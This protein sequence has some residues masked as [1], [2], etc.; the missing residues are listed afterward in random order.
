MISIAVD[1]R[2]RIR[3]FTPADCDDLVLYADNPGIARFL[4][5]AFPQPYTRRDA[6]AWVRI[7]SGARPETDLAIE[8]D[9]RCAGG[10]GIALRRD[11]ERFTGEIGFWVGE[12]FW[13]RGI[14]TR[15]VRAFVDWSFLAFDFARIEAFTFAGNPAS[16]RVLE[17]SGFVREGVRRRAAFKDGVFHD[18]VVFAR[19]REE[20]A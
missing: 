11:I 1:D 4:R 19:L 12:P 6:L 10:I 7:A 2:V 14:A 15:A 13:N 8:V 20:A 17:K 18:L 16:A 5:D 9:G 3:S